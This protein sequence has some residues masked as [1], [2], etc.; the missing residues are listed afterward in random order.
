MMHSHWWRSTWNSLHNLHELCIK[1]LDRSLTLLHLTSHDHQDPPS[2]GSFSLIPPFFDQGWQIFRPKGSKD[3]GR[4]G[5][6]I[7]LPQNYLL[8]FRYLFG[9][10]LTI[11]IKCI[12][13]CYFL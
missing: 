13:E 2:G 5:A 3:A 6:R 7:N 9:M 11:V 8:I 1:I 10:V 4:G 12:F